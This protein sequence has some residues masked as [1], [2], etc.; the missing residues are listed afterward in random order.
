M[1]RERSSHISSP[2]VTRPRSGV[3]VPAIIR[4]IVV[5]PAPDGPASARHWPG[6]TWSATSSSMSPTGPASSASS[7]AE[8]GRAYNESDSNQHGCGDDNQDRRKRER[9]R[10]IVCELVVDRQWHR[11]GDPPQRA[12]EHQR[13]AEFA[14]RTTPGERQ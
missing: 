9:G 12:R 4:R 14:K 6:A 7:T 10:K 13:G 8:N 1:P 3:W 11:L 5:L 2:Q